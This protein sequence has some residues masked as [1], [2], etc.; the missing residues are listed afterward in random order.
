MDS[1]SIVLADDH[2]LMRKG[3]IKLLEKNPYL[4]VVGEAND[5]HELLELLK[6]VSADL[7]IL[8]LG[9]P[10]LPGL[11]VAKK[12]KFFYPQIKVLI[13]SMYKGR[14]FF[15]KALEIGVDGYLL[16]EDADTELFAAIDTIRNG[17]NYISP[18]LS[19]DMKALL[20]QQ[21]QKARSKLGEACLTGREKEILSLIA[22]GK[23]GTDIAL[24]LS[25][26]PNTVESHRASIKRKLGVS[27]MAD[28]VKYAMMSAEY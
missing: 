2:I 24:Q 15:E 21:Y 3:L 13:L 12:L 28:L 4:K 23:S 22:A 10:N 18:L 9:M 16:K 26:S 20:F 27:R 5:G 11:E 17:D 14:E 1:C 25:I 7:V 19:H 6:S 8:D